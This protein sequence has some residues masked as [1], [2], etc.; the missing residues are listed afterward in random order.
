MDKI[1]EKTMK[2]LKKKQYD[3]SLCREPQRGAGDNQKACAGG[4]SS[5]A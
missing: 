3:G 5:A 2:N 1:I 4:Q